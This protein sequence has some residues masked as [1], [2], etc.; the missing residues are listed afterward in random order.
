M[1]APLKI[2][3][4][5]QNPLLGNSTVQ[6]IAI[7]L[8]ALLF[9]YPCVRHGITTGYD[10]ATHVR[11]QHHFSRQFW[12]GDFYPRWLAEENK[13]YGSPIFLIQYPLPYF[14][15][16]LLRPLAA[17]PST[18]DRDARELGVFM[19]VALAAAGV[20]ARFW[21]SKFSSTVAAT[22]AA[23][24]YLS[25]PYFMV[26]IYLRAAIGE[27]SALVF[28]PLALAFCESTHKAKCSIFPLSASFALLTISNPIIALLFI[29]VLFTYA[30]LSARQMGVT[31]AASARRLSLALI[32][33]FGLASIYLIPVLAYRGLFHLDGLVQSLPDFEV[34]RVTLIITFAMSC[35]LPLYLCCRF[36]PLSIQR[37]R[38]LRQSN[39]LSDS[40]VSSR[41]LPRD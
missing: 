6:L 32:L 11:Y 30:L 40:A 2:D 33:S 18:S 10:A 36:Q 31:L 16:A 20:A 37:F 26:G 9:T 13:G 41:L 38:F 28:M 7:L 21:F 17:F 4:H 15:T 5:H 34:G 27:V 23:V 19:F 39:S 1:R 35:P 24:A 25:L 14:V 29:P 3:L 8:W 12:R 22:V